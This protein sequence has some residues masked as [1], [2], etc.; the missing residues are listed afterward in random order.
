[1]STRVSLTEL[2]QAGVRLRPAEAVAIVIEVCRQRQEGRLRGVPSANVIRLTRNGEV[3]AEGP[4]SA[5]GPAVAQAADLLDEL[6]PGF[7]VPPEFRAPG[8]LRLTIARALGT[9]DVP[10]FSSLEEFCSATAR[11]TAPDVTQVACELFETWSNAMAARS[12]EPARAVAASTPEPPPITISDVRRARRATGL[13]LDEV[14]KRSRIP[15]SLLRELE[16]GYLRNWPSGLYGRSQLVRYARAAGLDERLV[17]DV[18]MPMIEQAAQDRQ[19]DTPEIV[20]AEQSINALLPVPDA[21]H[22]P[23]VPEPVPDPLPLQLNEPEAVVLTYPPSIGRR[24]SRRAWWVAAMAIPAAVAIAVLP[25]RWQDFSPSVTS[26]LSSAILTPPPI[27][28]KSEDHTADKAT[29]RSSLSPARQTVPDGALPLPSEAPS[30]MTPKPAAYVPAFT[31]TGTAI[32][33]HDDGGPDMTSSE[34]DRRGTILKITRVVDDNS[35]NFHA[36]PSPDGTHIAFDSD[37]EGERAIF[38]ADA[39]GRHVRRVSGEGFA[40]LPSWSPDGRLLAFV[41][42]EPDTPR[43][44]NVWTAGIESGQLDRLTS[45]TIG[46]PWG[47]SWFPD[48]DRLTY[49]RDDRLIVLN[50]RTAAQQVYKSPRPGYVVRTPVVSPDGRR[51]IFQVDRDGAWLLDLKSGSMRRVLDDPSAE[52]YAWSRDGRRVAFHSQRVGGWGVW[53]LGQ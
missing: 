2:H 32:F 22:L 30:R 48:G 18:A 34:R 4:V 29:D 44:W 39:D 33:F 42:A 6:L 28:E 36:R 46:Q 26:L 24:R 41:K 12:P 8:A 13:S 14:S 25:A 15:T 27:A 53:I 37:R 49:G 50:M 38:V 23:L 52:E 10:P 47:C 11:F 51:V 35:Q 3:V 43:V 5:D 45:D 17:V 21:S 1:M 31:N 20:P 40:A 19:P 7:G 9:L 16:W